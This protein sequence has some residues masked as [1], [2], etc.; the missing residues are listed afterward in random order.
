MFVVC[1]F[2]CDCLCAGG[3]GALSVSGMYISND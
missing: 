3:K 2:V 1:L